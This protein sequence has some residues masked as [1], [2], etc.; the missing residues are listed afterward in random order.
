M[1]GEPTK[2][3]SWV[4]KGSPPQNQQEEP[5]EPLKKKLNKLVEKMK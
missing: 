1:S 2:R 3:K 5:K 4:A